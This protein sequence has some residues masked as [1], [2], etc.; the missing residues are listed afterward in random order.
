MPNCNVS[1]RRAFTLVELL[2]VISI[3]AMLI[4]MLLPALSKARESA[5]M[6]QCLTHLR[7]LGVASAGYQQDNKTYFPA[8][9]TQVSSVRYWAHEIQPYS[10]T[11]PVAVTTLA[12]PNL[13]TC[14]TVYRNR[15][16]M[17]RDTSIA[18][19]SWNSFLGF[20]ANSGNPVDPAD[21][22]LGVPDRNRFR[23]READ[24][25]RAAQ[26]VLVMDGIT[27]RDPNVF[28]IKQ[29]NSNPWYLRE[30]NNANSNIGRDYWHQ[31]IA[32]RPG[33]GAMNAAFIDGHA[34][35]YTVRGIKAGWFKLRNTWR[36]ENNIN[37]SKSP[38]TW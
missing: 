14:P 23:M 18:D 26:T 1:S 5:N 25:Y 10:N 36:D 22:S 29:Q 21:Q 33:T 16:S 8:V 34:K 9:Y 3:V 38:V 7:Q 35:T 32:L 30:M 27:A 19:Y 28:Q 15:I 31:N 17:T 20:V 2:V 12:S 37:T 24:V 4:A 6:I 13:L 11:T